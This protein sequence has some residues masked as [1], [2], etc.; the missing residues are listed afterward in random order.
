MSLTDAHHRALAAFVI[1]H[2]DELE[3][4]ADSE[5]ETAWIAEA[6]LS[7]ARADGCLHEVP[8]R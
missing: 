6:L 3:T 4:Y 1:E 2:R 7:W 5:K 8:S